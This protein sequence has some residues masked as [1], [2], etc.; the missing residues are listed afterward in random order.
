MSSAPTSAVSAVENPAYKQNLSVAIR[1]YRLVQVTSN[2]GLGPWFFAP[3]ALYRATTGRLCVT[4]YELTEPRST[5]RDDGFLT[6][7]LS[8]LAQVSMTSYRFSPH[9]NFSSSGRK[10]EGGMICAV[11][12]SR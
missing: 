10:Y 9:P 1:T 4:G 5:M 8:R 7:E 11:D 2:E 12:C 3:H 6:L